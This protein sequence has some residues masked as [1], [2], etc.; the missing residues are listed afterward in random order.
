MI[1]PYIYMWLHS[2]LHI[3]MYI[4]FYEPHHSPVNL[5]TDAFVSFLIIM[6]IDISHAHFPYLYGWLAM[7]I[8]NQTDRTAQR[9]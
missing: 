9:K 1:T 3:F 5:F 8:F 6:H 4:I 7:K 2:F